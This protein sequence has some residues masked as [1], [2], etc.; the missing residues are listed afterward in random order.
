MTEFERFFEAWLKK[1]GTV[2]IPPECLTGGNTDS[3]SW[4]RKAAYLMFVLMKRGSSQ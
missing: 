2:E 1:L 3:V 4:D